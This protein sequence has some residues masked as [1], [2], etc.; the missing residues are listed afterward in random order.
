MVPLKELSWRRP[1]PWWE[2]PT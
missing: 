2:P 1:I